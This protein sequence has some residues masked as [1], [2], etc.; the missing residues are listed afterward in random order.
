MSAPVK[1]VESAHRAGVWPLWASAAVL[2]GLLL[3][4]LGRPTFAPAALA[5]NVSKA[6]DLTALTADAGGAEDVLAVLDRR[7]ESLLIY[8]ATRSGVD[9]AQTYDLKTVFAR[10]RAAAKR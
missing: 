1:R 8:T 5:G 3:F 7:A 10:A 6:G 9:L 4:Q 2:A